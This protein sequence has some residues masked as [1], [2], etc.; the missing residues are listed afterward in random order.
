MLDN[1]SVTLYFQEVFK[2]FNTVFLQI[3]RHLYHSL[4]NGDTG[5]FLHYPAWKIINKPLAICSIVK[6]IFDI[7]GSADE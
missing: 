3:A 1:S 7:S 4:A 2:C 6:K 5:C